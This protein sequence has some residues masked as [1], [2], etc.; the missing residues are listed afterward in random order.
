MHELAIAEHLIELIGK[1]V[2]ESGG[3]RA[4]R[5]TVQLG[6]MSGV[7]ADALLFCYE[8]AAKSTCAD[9]SELVIDSVPAVIECRSC[10]ARTCPVEFSMLCPECGGSDTELVQGRDL[11]L[12][13]I[14]V[15]NDV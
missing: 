8:L 6:E 3:Q 11:L 10:Q 12:R 13:E 7:M 15:I 4:V 5:V 14:E 2:R 1:H 9:G